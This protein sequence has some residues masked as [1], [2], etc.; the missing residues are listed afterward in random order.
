MHLVRRGHFPSRD[1]D[2]AKSPG[3]IYYRTGLTGDQSLQLRQ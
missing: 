2:G 3:V 1:E